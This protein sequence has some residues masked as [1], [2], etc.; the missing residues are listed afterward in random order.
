MFAGKARSLALSGAPER[1]FTWVGSGTKLAKDKRSS[2]LQ[3]FKSNKNAKC[4][5]LTTGTNV[6]KHFIII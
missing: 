3:K 6:K 1:C 5:L 2:L 4:Q